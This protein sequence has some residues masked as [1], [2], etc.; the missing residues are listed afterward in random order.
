MLKTGKIVSCHNRRSAVSASEAWPRAHD[1]NGDMSLARFDPAEWKVDTSE[2]R[3]APPLAMQSESAAERIVQQR[4]KL[5]GA[6]LA[7]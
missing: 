7:M 3:R 5:G 2:Q 4:V 1:T 6:C